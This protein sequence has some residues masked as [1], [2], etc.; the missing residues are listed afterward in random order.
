MITFKLATWTVRTLQDSDCSR[1]HRS[2]ILIAEELRCND[3]LLAR[4]GSCMRV[5]RK[6]REVGKPSSREAT[7]LVANIS[8]VWDWQS[9]TAF[10]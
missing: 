2:T 4:Q 3:V 1:P 9:G 5:L 7:P 8:M 6:E 10:Y